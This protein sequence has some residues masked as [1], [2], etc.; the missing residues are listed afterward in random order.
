MD[1]LPETQTGENQVK[2]LKALANQTRL[3]LFEYLQ[4]PHTVTQAANKFGVKSNGL[5]FHLRVLKEAGLVEKVRENKL[6][7]L[8]EAYY[9]AVNNFN[10]ERKTMPQDVPI[11]TLFQIIHG[12]TSSTCDDCIR[13][14]PPGAERKA[15][16]SRFFV[17][18][19]QDSLETIP[20]KIS[21][22]S[23]E[24]EKCVKAFDEEDGSL[25]YSVTVAHFEKPEE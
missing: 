13:S 12:I 3:R 9:Q 25:L 24:F 11:N 7:N 1:S 14:L 2:A 6:R 18:L 5:Y 20:K 21:K 19:K 15:F 4:Q 17:R 10:F 22:M 16:A 8:T 23:K